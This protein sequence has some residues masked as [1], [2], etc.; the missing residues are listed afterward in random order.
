M[1][2]L[3]GMLE[4]RELRDDYYE[5]YGEPERPSDFYDKLLST[6]SMPPALVRMELLGE[7][8]DD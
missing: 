7:S 4:L 2:Y 6:G 1:G 3:I 8:G 5:K